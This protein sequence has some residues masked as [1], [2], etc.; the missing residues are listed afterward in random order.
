MRGVEWWEALFGSLSFLAAGLSAHQ[1]FVASRI[2]LPSATG[3]DWEGRGPFAEALAKQSAV[4]ARAAYLASFAA[5]SKLLPW[6]QRSSGRS[7]AHHN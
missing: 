5:S 1:W 2:K 6:L 7:S 3:D 4:N